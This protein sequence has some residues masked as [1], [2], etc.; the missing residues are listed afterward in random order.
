MTST[1]SGW[2]VARSTFRI[3]LMAVHD[4]VVRLVFE[5]NMN[6]AMS[7]KNIESV[8]MV[9]R[10]IENY[11][12]HGKAQLID[13]KKYNQIPLFDQAVMD[14]IL[15]MCKDLARIPD[16]D[17]YFIQVEVDNVDNMM[18]GN[19]NNNGNG[20]GN[21]NGENTI[22]EIET[23]VKKNMILASAPT[24]SIKSTFIGCTA[25]R[26]ML[27]GFTPIIVLRNITEDVNQLER[28]MTN[29]INNIIEYL[30]KHNVTNRRIDLTNK[31]LFGS[32]LES[33]RTLSKF[34]SSLERTNPHFLI[35][36]ANET[37]LERVVEIVNEYPY[38]YDLFLDEMDG[39]D[40]GTNNHGVLCG[41]AT[42]LKIL[43]D[44]SHQTFG[45]TATP[46]DV[47]FSE[48]ELKAANQLRLTPPEDYRGFDDILVKPL[49]HE[50]YAL[51]KEA[52]YEELLNKDQNLASFLEYFS[53]LNPDFA[54]RH[55][56]YIPNICL[57]K[58]TRFIQ[59]QINL[60]MGINQNYPNLV[61]I[62]YNGSGVMMNFPNMNSITIVDKQ[63]QQNVFANVSI[64][65]VLQ[66]LYD[67]GGVK[68]FP[69]IV[70]IAGDLAGRGISY[71]TRNFHWH[72]TDMYYIPARNTPI[73]EIIQSA[74]RLCGRNRS[75][76]H[77]HLH[78]PM[79]VAE[80]LYNGFHFMDEVIARAIA[81]PLMEAT[82]ELSFSKS[83]LAV[84]MNKRKMPV[85]RELTGKVKVR[86]TDFNLTRSVTDVDGGRD[87]VTYKYKTVDE[88]NREIEELMRLEKET[89]NE[90]AGVE[91]SKSEEFTREIP[92]EEFIRLTTKMFPKWSKADTK[93]A[94]FMKNLDPRKIYTETEMREHIAEVD[95]KQI[96]HLLNIKTGTNGFGTILKKVNN[97]YQLYPELIKAFEENF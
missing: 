55:T 10:D 41:T 15:I 46:F 79:K 14:C 83:I 48:S 24:Q 66:W 81:Q 39:I 2:E 47:I 95:I 40:Y 89:Y 7:S 53:R 27:R 80:A 31:I 82:E 64:A 51:N 54:W 63:V 60:A 68:K 9:L 12:E 90:G 11:L 50:V 93:I 43:K 70:I 72:T 45:V 8:Q 65:D 6:T 52:S 18:I 58:N 61:T 84:R 73:H 38:R 85:G 26:S 71:V 4:K 16:L 44:K 97:T 56:Q 35:C 5:K 94:R 30:D 37:Q 1:Y 62:V 92:E 34:S 22:K 29:K 17:E 3:L 59:N 21:N 49:D 13:N 57:V 32:K 78:T 25:I 88:Y 20:N 28:G 67:N 23:M 87:I 86:K 74:G 19:G 42:L 75:M 36:L 77:L 33:E 91:E 76:S 69:R 96:A